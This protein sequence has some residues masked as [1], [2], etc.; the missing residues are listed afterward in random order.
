MTYRYCTEASNQKSKYAYRKI[1]FYKKSTA[2]DNPVDR[3]QICFTSHAL[4]LWVCGF[5]SWLTFNVL[6]VGRGKYLSW[7]L[8]PL[9]QNRC[10]WRQNYVINTKEH[11]FFSS[12]NFY[13]EKSGFTWLHLQKFLYKSDHFPRR[14]RRKQKWVFSNWNTTLYIVHRNT[15][16][17]L[18]YIDFWSGIFRFLHG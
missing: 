13:S 3:S 7:T 4:P 14:Y 11:L 8:N 9:L 5:P 16:C 15:L 17:S 12:K 1:F 18:C 10:T 2:L 6:C